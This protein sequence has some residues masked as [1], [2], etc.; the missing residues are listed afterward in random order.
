MGRSVAPAIPPQGLG[1]SPCWLGTLDV[2]QAGLK[3]ACLCLSRAGTNGAH[4]HTSYKP[5]FWTPGQHLGHCPVW[6][7][8]V[9]PKNFHF[10][11]APPE[12]SPSL[13]P[14][15]S[16][17]FPDSLAQLQVVT[18]CLLL[19]NKNSEANKGRVGGK[20]QGRDG[21]RSHLSRHPS[22]PQ[23]P[24]SSRHPGLGSLHGHGN[25]RARGQFLSGVLG[26]RGPQELQGAEFPSLGPE[27]S[28]MWGA[29]GPLFG[30]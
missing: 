30:N 12:G 19:K 27:V 28:R 22:H 15:L 14:T 17:T 1:L 21:A 24:S 8:H 25:S 16:R 6:D 9:P 4:H 3:F 29:E 7:F 11:K 26:W 13:A 2:D 23:R 10:P 5:G 18:F 20:T